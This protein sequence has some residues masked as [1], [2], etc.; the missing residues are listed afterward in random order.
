MIQKYKSFTIDNV[1]RIN[2]INSSIYT[3]LDLYDDIYNTFFK[4]ENKPK[5]LTLATR[6]ITNPLIQFIG[7]DYKVIMHNNGSEFKVS[8]EM[9]RPL[10][11][12]IQNDHFYDLKELYFDG[13]PK[14][15]TYQPYNQDCVKFTS[16]FK[17]IKDLKQFCKYLQDS[18]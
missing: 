17:N 2:V 16:I 7:K 1:F 11:L 18:F 14:E 13:F 12:N 6:P 8:V 4:S 15:Y 9:N 5:L 3:Q 10:T